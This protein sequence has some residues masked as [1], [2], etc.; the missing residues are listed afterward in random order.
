MNREER[1]GSIEQLCELNPPAAAQMVHD[2][3]HYLRGNFGELDNAA[4]IRFSK[5]IEHTK[6][7][8]SIE[9]V[10]FPDIEIVFNLK[11]QDFLI[12]ALSVQPLVENAIKHGV[13]K[14]PEGGKIEINS[15]EDKTYYYVNVKDN[16]AGFDIAILADRSHIG[17]RNIKERIRM[18]CRGTLTITSK[19]G[20]GTTVQIQIP[21]EESE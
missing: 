4:P 3:A 5:E 1:L 13:R 16:G 14:L 10:R 11:S 8:L 12:P 15:Y 7:Y 20:E 17:L 18:M 6:Y 2:F 19:T 21:K 9:K